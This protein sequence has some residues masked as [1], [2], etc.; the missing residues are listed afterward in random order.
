MVEL[1]HYQSLMLKKL[2]SEYENGGMRS[3][4]CQLP[5]GGGKSPIFAAFISQCIARMKKCLFLVHR[6]ELIYQADRHLNSCGVQPGCIMAGEEYFGCHDSDIASIQTIIRRD[7][8]YSRYDV[9][10]VDEAHHVAARSFRNVLSGLRE[11]AFV[12]GFTATPERTDGK[13]LGDI[14]GKLISGPS[15]AALQAEGYLAEV[16]YLSGKI[17]D[18]SGVRTTA[19]DWNKGDLKEKVAPVL[20][21]GVVDHYLKYGG[22]KGIVFSCGQKHSFWLRDEFSR[23]GKKALVIDA[24]TPQSDRAEMEGEFRANDSGI[25]I[26]CMV[27]DEGYD[28]PDCDTVVLATATKSLSR[29]MQ[30]I[31]RGM[32]PGVGKRLL[33]LDHGAN[34]WRHGGVE[35]PRDWH[36]KKSKNKRKLEKMIGERIRNHAQCSKCGAIMAGRKCANCG[37]ETTKLEIAK[38]VQELKQIGLESTPREKQRKRGTDAAW[39]QIVKYCANRGFKLGAAVHTYRARFGA[40]PWE[41]GLAYLPRSKS[42]WDVS[43]ADWLRTSA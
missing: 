24:D 1:R 30:M 29:Y 18:L 32:R 4:L 7:I 37:H 14:F 9:V 8:N 40:P 27:Y 13:P 6:R 31:G 15:V 39:I 3:V 25:L 16:D 12:C 20:V 2:V 28:A 17:P 19:G 5:T 42:G 36:L 35:D 34:W 38:N 33:V 11:D 10:V 21:G 22:K 26:N 43:A 23:K 41:D